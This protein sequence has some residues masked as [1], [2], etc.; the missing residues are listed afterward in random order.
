[1]RQSR[2]VTCL[3]LGTLL[4]SGAGVLRAQETAAGSVA[5]RVTD[6]T[7]AVLPAVAVEARPESGGDSRSAAT[8]ASGDYRVE[9][10]G[11]G[12][13][14]VSFHLPN[15]ASAVSHEVT[16]RAGA[17]TR[18]D[19]TLR[20]RLSAQ[21]IVTAPL[22]FRDLSTVKT[23]S[24]LIGIASS[25]TSG[26][27]AGSQLE[28]RPVARPGDLAERVPG[29]I[30]SQ[31][32]GEG[33]ANQ[34]YVRGFNI[35]HGTDLALSVAGLPVNLPTNGHGQG[36][37]DLNF[38][39]P[40]LVGAIQ[41]KKGTYYAEEG[42]FS[43]A[44]A[45]HMN[46]LNVLERP[47]AKV[48]AGDYG[49]RRALLAASP[50]LGGG[51]LLAALELGRNDG[52]WVRPDAFRKLNGVVRYSRG[53]AQSGFSLTGMLYDAEWDSTDQVPA[54]AIESGEISRFGYID[55]TDG[56][57]SHR[58]S[59]IAAWQRGEARS[60][61]RVEGFFSEYGMNLLSNFTYFLSDPENGD[62][63]EQRDDRWLA[64]LR[65]SRLWVLGGPHQPTEL[66]A[67]LQLRYDDI[68]PV[69]LYLTNARQR[70]STTREDAVRQRSV[71]LYVQAD[72]QW[73]S[74]VR[75]V[76]GVRGDLYDVDVD[77]S[78]PANSGT[79]TATRPS[80]KLTLVLGPWNRTEIYANYGWGFHSNDARGATITRDPATGAPAE[81]VDPLVR[82]R[83][84]ELGVRTL[85]LP[86]LHATAALWGLDLD[87]ELLFVGDAGTT[88]PSRPSERRGVELTADYSPRPWLKL[89][90]SY[91][92]SRAR[93]NDDDPAG[94]RIPGAI[95]GVFA[96]GVAVH[97][98]SRWS[99]SMR[100]RWF[101]PRPLV[102]DDSVRSK[103]STLVS[104]DLAF[105][106]RPGWAIQ[107]SVFNLFDAEVADIDYFYTSRLPGEPLEGVA[108]VHTHPSA[109]RTFRIGLVASF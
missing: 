55:P 10:L 22:T 109:P 108:E 69:G 8:D 70:L 81:R 26:V 60:L 23:D 87:S 96:A 41:Y 101:G 25:A 93:F 94:D 64:G 48:E 2:E 65:A 56:G 72:T 59:L 91:A 66:T 37:A 75:T 3:L 104:A 15:F 5:G 103:S 102:E 28:D 89:D 32:S 78:D 44:G 49:Y 53:T 57:Q 33:K 42:D 84:A 12:A 1:M 21:V 14:E 52:P 73:T 11:S 51:S 36:Y 79:E 105:L 63:F 7:G 38:V 58:H 92:R 30:V 99:G 24:E 46:Y 34:Y 19:T 80:P 50:R 107:A 20:L 106:L 82:G 88:E 29:V 76:V 45:V 62:Q 27:V 100:A 43:A 68:S 95:E 40:E 83:G 97:E 77:S 13:W 71:A 6:A 90:A 74:K 61:T 31:H 98:L 86:G 18:L 4:S 54:R 85:A 67:G 39:I 16:V 9:G 35:D 17:E 47:I